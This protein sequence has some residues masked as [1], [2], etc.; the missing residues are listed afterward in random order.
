MPETIEI[1][2]LHPHPHNPRLDKGKE[3][4]ARLTQLM[5]E[6]GFDEHAIIIRPIS[7]GGYQIVSGH[8]RVQAAKRAGLATV[9]CWKREPEGCSRAT[10][11]S[12]RGSSGCGISRPH[13]SMLNTKPGGVPF[14]QSCAAFS[15]TGSRVEVASPDVAGYA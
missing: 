7:H 9:P 10:A 4:I 8:R 15:E 5:K 11:G 3:T 14:H 13:V 6:R 12:R 1:A 2:R